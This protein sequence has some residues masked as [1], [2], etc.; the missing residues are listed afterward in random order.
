MSQYCPKV[1]GKE[2]IYDQSADCSHY[3]PKDDAPIWC[4]RPK[5]KN[6]ESQQ[7]KDLLT[8]L[9]GYRSNYFMDW[10]LPLWSADPKRLQNLSLAELVV[11]YDSEMQAP[12]NP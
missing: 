4:K 12:H 8:R 2:I 10:F 6:L 5:E 1:G 9:D 7:Q 11:K 3:Q